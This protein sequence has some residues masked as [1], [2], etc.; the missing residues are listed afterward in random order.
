LSGLPQ[1]PQFDFAAIPAVT[2]TRELALTQRPDILAA[3]A[4]YAQ[5]ESELRLEL[6]KQY[7]DIHIA[8][9][10]GWDQGFARWSLGL[11]AI[12]PLLSRNRGPIAEA[13]ARRK[14]SETRFAA[15]QAKVIGALD[16]AEARL[17]Q[18]KARIDEAD[19]VIAL[20][21]QRVAEVRRAFD[22]GEEDRLALRTAELELQSAL[23]ARVDALAEVHAAV[24]AV[25]D[26]MQQEAK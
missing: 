22:A 3:L 20:D 9:G 11:S 17:Q 25:E 15:L 13:E 18:A 23:V 26:G 6:A 4:D 7:P 14:E 21:R 16:E 10:F 5:S 8:P 24:G 12:A 19:A 2:G 1:H